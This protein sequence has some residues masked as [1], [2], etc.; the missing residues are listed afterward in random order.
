MNVLIFCFLFPEYYQFSLKTFA[1]TVTFFMVGFVFFLMKIMGGGDSKY[2]AT[3][4]LLV[5]IELQDEAFLAL[6]FTTIIMAATMFVANI[7]LGRAVIL[8]AWHKRDVSLVKTIFGKKF[9][10]AP[11][12]LVSWLW[13]GIKN[14]KSIHF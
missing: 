6:L 8:E 2:L 7:I 10:Y 14:Y 5:P 1:Y 4:Y 13:F 12:I 9:A 11:L 3:F